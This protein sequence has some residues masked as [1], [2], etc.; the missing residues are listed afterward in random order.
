MELRNISLPV[1]VLPMDHYGSLGV[2]RSL[3]RLGVEVYG[4]HR[5]Q[6]PVASF[7]RY[8]RRVFKLDLDAASPQQSVENLSNFARKI[9]GRPLLIAT[10]DRTALFVAQNGSG[11]QESFLFPQN[12]FQVVWSLYNKKDMYFLAK[13]LSIPTA[14]TAFPK[15]RPDVVEVCEKVRFPVM[16]KASDNI[17]VSRRTGRRMVIAKSKDELLAYYDAMEDASNPDLMIQEY[18]PGK[19]NSVWMFN[20]Y[21]DEHSD[22]VFGVT[23]RKIHQTPVYTGMTA[24]GM[25]HPN[26]AIESATK[27][28]VKALGYRGILDIGYRYDARDSQYKL[29]DANPRLGAT[30]RL[31]VAENGM[32]VVRAQY[33]HFTEQPIPACSV[34]D[35]R[36]WI[37]EDEHLISC[38]RY[39]R[40]GELTLSDWIACYTGIQE[41]A[42]FAADDIKPFL[43]MCSSFSVRPFRK[44][45][46]EGKRLLARPSE[47]VVEN[48]NGKGKGAAR[49]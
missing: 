22:C 30:F 13:Q 45:F 26:P 9:G 25:C 49:G 6:K 19:D 5:T 33:L 17:R 27:T 18:I 4:V 37:V 3:G 28:L 35:G 20:G 38:I 21:F 32:D 16:L 40:D 8:C 29:L 24:L 31:F 23:A 7:S 34:S 11:L 1:L 12:R 39:Y 36:K 2:I 48:G 15:S 46:R 42:W 44:I 14:E 43:R 10:D 47:H 41:C